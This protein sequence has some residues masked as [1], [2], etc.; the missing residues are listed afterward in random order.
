MGLR[1]VVV[2]ESLPASHR[3]HLLYRLRSLLSSEEVRHALQF[4]VE[5]A[6][7]RSGDF[8]SDGFAGYG[9]LRFAGAY[10]YSSPANGNG[11]VHAEAGTADAYHGPRSNGYYG[12]GHPNGN[13]N[14]HAY[15][16]P[17]RAAQ[18]GWHYQTERHGRPSHL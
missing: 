3:E 2:T 18:T 11:N 5:S 6:L 12:C 7:I 10:G 16:R 17:Q 15:T 13:S 4:L 8:C 14:C 1:C 9:S